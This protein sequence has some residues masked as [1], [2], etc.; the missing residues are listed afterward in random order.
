MHEYAVDVCSLELVKDVAQFL[1]LLEHGGLVGGMYAW[2]VDA[3][4]DG[5]PYC[6]HLCFY[7]GGLC[8]ERSVLSVEC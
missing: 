1:L 5:N 8:A 2:P 3:S 6:S 7:N 4:N